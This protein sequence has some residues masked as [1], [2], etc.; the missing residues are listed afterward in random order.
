MC[1]SMH[2]WLGR[3]RFYA[4]QSKI[5]TS[6]VVSLGERLR[7]QDER[8]LP[9]HGTLGEKIPPQS[10]RILPQHGTLGE[11]IPPQHGILGEKIPPQHG[12][13]GEKYNLYALTFWI[14]AI[15]QVTISIQVSLLFSC[16]LQQFLLPPRKLGL[17]DACN[18]IPSISLITS[19]CI[20]ISYCLIDFTK[21]RL[22][23]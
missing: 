14:I 10:K 1:I 3:A 9:Q 11:K 13:L 15:N 16:L 5:R 20:I 22:F 8:L 2:G 21:I 7:P 12:T 23:C 18:P 6:K 4:S 19:F 17:W